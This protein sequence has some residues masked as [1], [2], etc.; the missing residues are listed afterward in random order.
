MTKARYDVRC[1]A[2]GERT[3]PAERFCSHC[4]AAMRAQGYKADGRVR[5]AH[6]AGWTL[7]KMILVLV[8]LAALAGVAFLIYHL[9]FPA[10]AVEIASTTSTAIV[11]TTTST[12][13]APAQTF[14]LIQDTDRYGTAI[15]ISKQGFPQSAPAVVLAPGDSFQEALCAAPLATAYGGPLLFVSPDGLTDDVLSELERLNPSQVFLVGVPNVSTAKK[16]LSG[17]PSAPVVTSLSGG[18][19]YETAALVA[20]QLKTKL[21]TIAKVVIV[22]QGTFAEGLAV[23]PLAAT[24]GWPILFTSESQRPPKVTRDAI[25]ELAVTSALVVGS[26]AQVDVAQVERV[27]GADRYDTCAQV[28]QYGLIHGL[29]LGHVAFATGE[30][31]PDGLAAGPYLALDSGLLLLTKGNEVPPSIATFLSANI[32]EVLVFDFIALPGLAAQM[33][34]A[35]TTST[36][37][38]TAS[39]TTTATTP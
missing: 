30:A 7:V 9:L 17:L 6:V 32:D 11:E 23:A 5:V 25:A 3:N 2:C 10:A 28:A 12:T 20:K 4:G 37:D 16:N 26:Q 8:P 31:F 39:T 22:P 29:K 15:A 38:G 36:T 14:T 35:A 18:D 24:Q 13:A 19:H 1:R 27:A 34:R 33:E 21:G